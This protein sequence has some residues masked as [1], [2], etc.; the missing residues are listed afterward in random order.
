MNLTT[1]RAAV[2]SRMGLPS[3]DSLFDTTALDLLI[4]AA[5]RQIETEGDWSWLEATETINTSN[6]DGSYPLANDWVRTIAVQIGNDAP[7]KRLPL[8]EL[9]YMGGASGQPLYFGFRGDELQLRPVPAG[10]HAVTHTYLRAEA[11]LSA[12]GDEPYLPE[13]FHPAI[14]EYG[15]YIGFRRSNNLEDAGAALA[16]YEGWIKRM[17]SRGSRLS[18]EEGGGE[19]PA[20]EAAAETAKSSRKG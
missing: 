11:A 16:A 17:L 18:V 19:V 7:L 6:G 8:T 3:G 12:D 9:L 10:V 15:A 14:V 4:N 2:L 5:L 1:F 20:A 13:P